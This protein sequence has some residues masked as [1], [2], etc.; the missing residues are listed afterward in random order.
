M[1]GIGAAGWVGVGVAKPANPPPATG[2]APGP[3]R[4]IT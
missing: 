3:N 2:N 1:K 4:C